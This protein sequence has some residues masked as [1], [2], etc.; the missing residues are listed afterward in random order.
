MKRKHLGRVIDTSIRLKT[1]PMQAWE[2]WADPQQIANWFVDRASGDAKPGNTMKWFFD[3][4]HYA[5]DVPIVEA[6]PGRTFVTGSG[7][8][9]GPDGIPYLMEITIEK[10]G[11]H[12]IMNLVNSG[13]SDAPEKDENFRGTVSGWEGALT[14]LKLWLERYPDRKR[15]HEIVMRPAPPYKP[16]QLRALYA[17]TDGRRR[18]LEP[19]VPADGEVLRDTG[20][21]IMLAWPAQDAI[22]GLK[23]FPAGPQK[24]L[25]LDYS[26]WPRG[27]EGNSAA[28]TAK[29]DTTARLNRALDRLFA[30]L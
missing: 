9:P 10:D 22:L 15:R 24:M 18:W 11:D 23:A 17:T 21:E 29:A 30:L 13:F 27:D 3:A 6:E 26:E 4:F 28:Q 19:D 16:E 2:A 25:A 14:H 8:Q 5:L 20:S 1:T 7:D 12:T